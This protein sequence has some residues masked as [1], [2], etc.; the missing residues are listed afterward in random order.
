MRMFLV[1]ATRDE[2]KD[3]GCTELKSPFLATKCDKWISASHTQNKFVKNFDT[4]K[5]FK[6]LNLPPLKNH[7]PFISHGPTPPHCVLWGN[8]ASADFATSSA[9]ID[10]DVAEVVA[11]G[12]LTSCFG[13]WFTIRCIIYPHW[14]SSI[15]IPE[16]NSTRMGGACHTHSF[17]AICLWGFKG[18]PFHQK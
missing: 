8:N 11:P 14:K 10:T 15:S 16:G 13:W 12:H 3:L 17:K 4:I 5:N 7:H 1:N 2:N 9:A 6:H 18:N